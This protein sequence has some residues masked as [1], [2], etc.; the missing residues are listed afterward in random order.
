MFKN[1]FKKKINKITLLGRGGLRYIADKNEYYIDSD[2]MLRREIN[3]ISIAIYYKGIKRYYNGSD[4][5]D[6]TI[7]ISEDEKK[8]VA[9]A[10]KELLEESGGKVGIF[11]SL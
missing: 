5:I 6:E 2:N 7:I 10:V 8:R 3:G 9:I 11:P 4:R 1:F